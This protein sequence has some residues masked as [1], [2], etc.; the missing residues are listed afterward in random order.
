MG[1]RAS[2]GKSRTW[3]RICKINKIK[4]KKLYPEIVVAHF[5]PF[6]PLTWTDWG[7]GLWFTCTHRR[8]KVMRI[9]RDL[10]TSH[11]V[12]VHSNR[13]MDAALPL[14]RGSGE[15]GGMHASRR[16]PTKRCD[17][18]RCSGEEMERERDAG[19]PGCCISFAML[20][21]LLL[22]AFLNVTA[23]LDPRSPRCCIRTVVD[24]N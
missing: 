18:T 24:K 4:L 14:N 21:M 15:R 17:C 12:I 16:D 3:V 13:M 10:F 2:V 23:A 11:V 9:A 1:A 19:M 20:A 22:F 7:Q 6:F 8:G 5:P